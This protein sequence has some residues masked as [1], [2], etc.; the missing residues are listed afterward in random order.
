VGGNKVEK[1]QNQIFGIFGVFA[2]IDR[3]K[4]FPL[5]DFVTLRLVELMVKQCQPK[6]DVQDHPR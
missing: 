6:L 5:E 2:E 1:S 4:E 3:V